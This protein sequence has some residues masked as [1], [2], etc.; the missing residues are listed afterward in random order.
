[1]SDVPVA[2]LLSEGIDSN[3]IRFALESTGSAL[4]SFTYAMTENDPGLFRLPPREALPEPFELRVDPRGRLDHIAPAFS[5]FTEPLG[6]G[7]SLAT[8]LLIKNARAEATV[9]LCGHGADEIIG[10]YRLSQDRFRL[11]AIHR[12]AW[13]PPSMLDLLIENKVFG[14]EPAAVRQRAV[15]RARRRQVPAASRYLTHRPLPV[16]DLATLLGRGQLPEPYLRSV[17]ELYAACDDA[18]SD[19]DRIQEVMIRTFLSEDILSFADSVA[20]DSSAELRMPFLDRDLVEFVFGLHPSLR[21]SAWPGRANTKQILRRWARRHLP[22]G[23][24]GRRKWNFNY[25]SARD[26]LDGERS[27]FLDLVLGSAAVRRVLPGLETWLSR[28]TATFRGPR[29]GTLWAILA[30]AVWGEAAAIR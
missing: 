7:A 8:W 1:V 19:L 5:S 29:E 30:L 26:F 14:A 27:Q 3:A 25:G 15:W 10:G 23:F 12:L 22:Q 13:L 9:F 21:V 18:A 11:A 28:P 16:E 17:D 20:M 2:L 4:P 6:D 24:A